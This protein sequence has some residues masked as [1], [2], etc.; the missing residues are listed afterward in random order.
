MNWTLISVLAILLVNIIIGLRKG[1]IK[2]VFSVLSMM[3]VI[4][5]TSILAPRLSVALIRNT[6]WDDRLLQ[7]TETFLEERGVLKHG[8]NIDVNEIPLPESARNKVAET[9]EIY[10]DKGIEKYNEYVVRTVSDVVF[11]ALVYVGLFIILMIIVAIAS[12]ILN[13]M[14]RLPVLKQLNRAGGALIGA[15]I[16][17]ASV[18]ILF[19]IL[20]VFSGTQAMMPVFEQIKE[21]AFLS[22]LY[23][24]NIL[25][26][27]VLAVF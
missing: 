2:M 3:I 24:K 11:G 4:V 13:V 5:L 7:R 26:N 6:E 14:S 21:N 15:V 17:L 18:W 9:T 20:T 12:A 22:F 27:F 19:M 8:V 10:I 25:M 23:D 1:L 16:G